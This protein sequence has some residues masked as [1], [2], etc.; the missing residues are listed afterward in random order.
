MEC[1]IT[2][3]GSFAEIQQALYMLTDGAH[4]DFAQECFN[5]EIHPPEISFSR[6]QENDKAP[7]PAMERIEKVNKRGRKKKVVAQPVTTEEPKA[8]GEVHCHTCGTLFVPRRPSVKHC[9]K[10]CYMIE[11]REKNTPA[12]VAPDAKNIAPDAKMAE[13]KIDSITEK[14]NHIRKTCP[15][16]K[17]RPDFQRDIID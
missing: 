3:T 5:P 16:P 4:I 13:K 10:R 11:W 6:D 14:L 17:P 9:S 2:I 12:K 8:A 7:M 1:K 15:A